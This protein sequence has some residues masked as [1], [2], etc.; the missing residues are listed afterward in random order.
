MPD[1]AMP[2][3]L[4][5]RTLIGLIYKSLP[6]LVAALR[7]LLLVT[8]CCFWIRGTAGC[9]ASSPTQARV[10][11]QQLRQA[12]NRIHCARDDRP[13][14]HCRLLTLP[15]DTMSKVTNPPLTKTLSLQLCTLKSTLQSGWSVR[16][17]NTVADVSPSGSQ[18]I[19]D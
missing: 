3:S 13:L 2:S 7:L 5:T 18:M 6:E 9:E 19:E 1:A 4:L 17:L 16:G 8:G 12:N 15:F 10:D 11:A 14:G